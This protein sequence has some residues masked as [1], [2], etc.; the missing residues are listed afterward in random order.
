[1]LETEPMS[2]TYK[3]S[4]VL[5]KPSLQPTISYS[6]FEKTQGIPVTDG[7]KLDVEKIH[8]QENYKGGMNMYEKELSYLRKKS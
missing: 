5:S 7:A 8:D 2:S 1:M 6:V 4:L 3:A